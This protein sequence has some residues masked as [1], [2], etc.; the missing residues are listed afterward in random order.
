M[1]CAPSH[2][3]GENDQQP[4]SPGDPVAATTS[5]PPVS[6]MY[7]G[8]SADLQLELRIDLDGAHPLER[9]SGDLYKVTGG[10]VAYFGS[11]IVDSLSRQVRSDFESVSGTA[12]FTFPAPS[13]IVTVDIPRVPF[14]VSLPVATVTFSNTT[15]ASEP[16]ISCAFVSRHFRVVQWE[17]DSVAGTAPFDS[18]DVSLLPS[19]GRART[20]TIPAAYAEAGIEVQ[21]AGES[22]AFPGTVGETWSNAELHASMVEHFSLR[23][24]NPQWRVWLLVAT[25]HDDERFRG[26]MFDRIGRH[27]QGCAVFSSH[28]GDDIPHCHRAALRTYVHELGHCF[29]LMHSWQKSLAVPPQPIR[30]DALSYMNYV[31]TYPGGAD[32]YWAAF[33]FQFDHSELV[34]LRHGF[35]NDVIMGGSD[36]TSGAADIDELMV[37]RPLIDRSGLELRLEGASRNAAASGVG[38]RYKLGEPVVVELRLAALDAHGRQVHE[39]IHPNH[40]LVR[41]VIRQPNGSLHLFRPLADHCLE[42]RLVTA[43]PAKPLYTSAYIGYGK[44]GFTFRQPGFYEIRAMYEAPDGSDVVSNILRVRVSSPRSEEEDG[45]ADLYFGDDQGKLFTFLGSDAPSLTSG[46]RA[47]ENVIDRYPA[48]RLTAYAH[49]AKGMNAK[50]AFKFI[51]ADKTLNRRKA[52]PGDAV[53]FLQAAAS[54]GLLDNVTM[55]KTMREVAIAQ[56]DLG[57]VGAA[58]QTLDLMVRHFELQQLRPSVLDTIRAQARRTAESFAPAYE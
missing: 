19:G 44:D 13:P 32:A 52:H 29:N 30:H 15:G 58:R 8:N 18:Y 26:I 46:N 40:G 16:P 54:A 41:I 2:S 10:T 43:T 37:S 22:N 6:G 48:H 39:H 53:S 49:L 24:D 36:F 38:H 55:N 17:Q 12:R 3:A 21:V 51:T 45:I 35:R 50:R 7:R 42:T 31:D 11:F 5:W 23:A 14:G 28:I 57:Q 4:F 47:L 56:A 34:H 9:I 27:R 1:S 33:P 25:R 20:L